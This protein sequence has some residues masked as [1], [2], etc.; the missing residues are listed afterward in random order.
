MISKINSLKFVS[1]KYDLIP[2][3][4]ER[5][6]YIQSSG[7]QYINT[8]V[9]NTDVYGY[10]VEY[11]STRIVKTQNYYT[12][13]GIFGG[14]G[15]TRDTKIWF[16]YPNEDTRRAGIYY[17]QAGTNY[18]FEPEEY[19]SLKHHIKVLDNVPYYNGEEI[20]ELEAISAGGKNSNYYLYIFAVNNLGTP[21]FHSAKNM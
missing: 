12:L 20:G 17:R 21:R 3:I 5:V 4:Y 9:L 14:N 15:Y 1:V 18:D 7:T 8:G 6:S 19:F 10:E 13:D 11:Q 2:A 16:S